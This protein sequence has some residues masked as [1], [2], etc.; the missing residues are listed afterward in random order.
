MAPTGS[1]QHGE[2]FGHDDRSISWPGA[3]RRREQAE[4]RA[5]E[6]GVVATVRGRANGEG[7]DGQ[8]LTVIVVGWTASSGEDRKSVV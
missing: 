1:T 2:Q 3:R 8:K 7:E 4:A 5:G 6:R